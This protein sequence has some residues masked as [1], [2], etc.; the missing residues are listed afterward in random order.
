MTRQSPSAVVR[1]KLRRVQSLQG[2]LTQVGAGT[3]W[4]GMAPQRKELG[5]SQAGV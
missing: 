3:G 2:D 4:S 1:E 5:E